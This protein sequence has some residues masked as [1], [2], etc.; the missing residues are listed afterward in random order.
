MAAPLSKK[1]KFTDYYDE[2]PEYYDE[3]LGSR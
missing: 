1:T 2:I 3:F